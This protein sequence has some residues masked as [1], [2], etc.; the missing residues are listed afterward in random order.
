MPFDQNSRDS[1]TSEV[2]G[3]NTYSFSKNL[4]QK[5]THEFQTPKKGLFNIDEK[6]STSKPNLA[7]IVKSSPTS[8]CSEKATLKPTV[9]SPV[10]INQKSNGIASAAMSKQN[11]LNDLKNNNSE[12]VQKLLSIT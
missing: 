6:F 1:E 8:S 3:K 5:P 4:F 9:F 12:L 2:L 10:L 7:G 11:S